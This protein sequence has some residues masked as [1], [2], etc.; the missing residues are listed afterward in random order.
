MCRW[1]VLLSACVG[2]WVGR[3]DCLWLPETTMVEGSPLWGV[4]LGEGA[5]VVMVVREG[6][7]S[8]RSEAVRA[9]GLSSV[10]AGRVEGNW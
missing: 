1:A 8:H 2:G 9:G 5:M 3:P 4:P 6:K 7:G 10:L